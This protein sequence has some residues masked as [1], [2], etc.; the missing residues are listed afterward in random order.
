MLNFIKKPFKSLVLKNYFVRD[1]YGYFDLKKHVW[2]TSDKIAMVNNL[3]N[4]QQ[5]TG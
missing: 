5:I 2:I 1:M 4:N 3:N